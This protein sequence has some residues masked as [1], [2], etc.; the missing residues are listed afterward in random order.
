LRKGDKVIQ[1]QKTKQRRVWMTT[2]HQ[3]RRL[4][5]F[6]RGKGDVDENQYFTR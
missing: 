4:R 5:M 2:D 3:L 6:R 1:T